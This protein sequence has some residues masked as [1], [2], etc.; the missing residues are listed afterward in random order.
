MENLTQEIQGLKLLISAL[1]NQLKKQEKEAYDADDI[2]A[3]LGVG[4]SKA[5]E[6]IREVRHVSDALG[7]AGIC[8][9]LDY[10]LWKEYKI[11]QAKR[12]KR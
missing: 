7:T 8:H 2:K 12:G 5:Y 10:E 11:E 4:E 1:V 9:K 3:L 6:V